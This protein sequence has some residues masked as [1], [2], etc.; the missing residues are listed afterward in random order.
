MTPTGRDVGVALVVVG[1]SAATGLAAGALWAAVSPSRILVV[2]TDG[3]IPELTAGDPTFAAEGW[4]AVV[5]AIAGVLLAVW[6]WRR[7]REDVAAL[8]G[9]TV[10][11]VLG[12]VVAWRLGRWL[13][14]DP[15]PPSAVDLAVGTRVPEPIDVRAHATLL[16]WPLVAVATYFSLTVG[17]H[18]SAKLSPRD[19]SA[20]S[21]PQ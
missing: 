17:E 12:A 19:V 15:L 1:V 5:G 16:I 9:L 13:G 18:R 2:G 10:G 20:P 21:E 8:I 7:S 14:P 11:G 3:L 6:A 4:F